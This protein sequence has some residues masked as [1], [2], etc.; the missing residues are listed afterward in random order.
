MMLEEFQHQEAQRQQLKAKGYDPDQNNQIYLEGELSDY[1]DENEVEDYDD[2]MEEPWSKPNEGP[3]IIDSMKPAFYFNVKSQNPQ[4]QRLSSGDIN[5]TPSFINT[6]SNSSQFGSLNG[7]GGIDAQD[8]ISAM[9]R[10]NGQ[11]LKKERVVIQ[12]F[13]GQGDIME[14]VTRPDSS[15]QQQKPNP[16]PKPEKKQN[17]NFISLAVGVFLNQNNKSTN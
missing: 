3:D 16:K 2:D 4:K 6:P 17:V 8:L 9:K 11:P 10:E 15:Y 1:G 7:T 5:M 14:E 12:S 13:G